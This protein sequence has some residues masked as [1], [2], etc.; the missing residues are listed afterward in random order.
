MLGC[1]G[2]AE[3]GAFSGSQA[4]ASPRHGAQ[5][6][7]LARSMHDQLEARTSHATAKPS[8]LFCR[9]IVRRIRPYGT[10]IMALS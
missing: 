8:P 1:M 6:S 2:S 7:A 10:P 5:P 4:R 9:P 3:K